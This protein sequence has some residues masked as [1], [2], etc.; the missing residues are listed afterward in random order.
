MDLYFCHSEHP[1]FVTW[2]TKTFHINRFYS[3]D[4]LAGI[5]SIVGGVLGGVLSLLVIII[6]ALLVCIKCAG[7]VSCLYIICM[8]L[9]CNYR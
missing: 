3:V 9:E 5:G 8:T 4:V 2:C 1:N 6:T 7:R